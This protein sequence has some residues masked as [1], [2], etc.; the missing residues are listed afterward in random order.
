MSDE[1]TCDCHTPGHVVLHMTPCCETC[2]KCGS[3]IAIEK[4]S[5]HQEACVIRVRSLS[6]A[7]PSVNV[8]GTTLAALEFHA[9]SGGDNGEMARKTLKAITATLEES[10]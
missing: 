10:K 5:S 6:Q 3:R 2:P 1:C 8:E 7:T 9:K 4:W